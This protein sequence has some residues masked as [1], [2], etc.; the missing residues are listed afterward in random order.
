M[1]WISWQKKKKY[2]VDFNTRGRYFVVRRDCNMQ[3]VL[4]RHIVSLLCVCLHYRTSTIRTWLHLSL[5][6]HL[7]DLTTFSLSFQLMRFVVVYLW[8]RVCCPV[9]RYKLVLIYLTAV[10]LNSSWN[11]THEVRFTTK[12]NNCVQ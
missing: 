10:D 4:G 5:A 11:S 7:R 3:I 12:I 2:K 8:K 6:S 1:Q 9:I